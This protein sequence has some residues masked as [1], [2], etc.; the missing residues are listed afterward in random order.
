METEKLKTVIDLH[1]QW[2]NDVSGG[3]RADL[4]GANLLETDLS[5]ADLSVADLSGADLTS[6]TLCGATIDGVIVRGRD[7]G[8]PG[9]ILCALTD[10]EW[11]SI[12]AG[13]TDTKGAK[14]G[15][16]NDG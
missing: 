7:I 11:A 6:I 1:K 2:L 4:S 12:D 14:Y 15:N 9:H 8:G 13:R 5:G 10:S 16:G 3:S